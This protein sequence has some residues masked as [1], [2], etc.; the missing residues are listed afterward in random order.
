M[1]A[2]HKGDPLARFP[3]RGVASCDETGGENG[4]DESGI[5]VCWGTASVNFVRDHRRD[6]SEYDLP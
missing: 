4:F 6:M 3:V 1:V 2:S 5:G